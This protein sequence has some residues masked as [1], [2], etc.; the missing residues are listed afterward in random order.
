M[1]NKFYFSS[2]QNICSVIVYSCFTDNTVCDVIRLTG[3]S[4][5][6]KFKNVINVVNV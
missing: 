6:A 2:I 5:V 4:V 3:K 1:K